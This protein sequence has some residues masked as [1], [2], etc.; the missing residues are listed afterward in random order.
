M[1]EIEDG[2]EE[3]VTILDSRYFLKRKPMKSYCVDRGE[4]RK[5]KEITNKYYPGNHDIDWRYSG[6]HKVQIHKDSGRQE[7][8]RNRDSVLKYLLMDPDFS[9]SRVR[10]RVN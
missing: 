6:R 8:R 9:R 10:L 5:N 2:E 7:E 4:P 3:D 1:K